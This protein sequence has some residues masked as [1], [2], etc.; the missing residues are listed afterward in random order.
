MAAN[1]QAGEAPQPLKVETKAVTLEAVQWV[2]SPDTE[3]QQKARALLTDEKFL[4]SLNSE[5]EYLVFP[6]ES[7]QLW[8]V[9]DALARNAAPPAIETLNIIAGNPLYRDPGPRRTVLL[10]SSQNA[11]TPPANVERFWKEQVRPNA[12]ELNLAVE[13][14][15]A[16]GSP[17]AIKILE[18]E[19]LRNEH[20][21]DYLVAWFQDPILRH[22]QDLVLLEASERLLRTEKWSEDLKHSLVEALFDYR[23]KAWYLEENEPPKPP[24]RSALTEAERRKLQE[25]ADLAAQNGWLTRERHAQIQSELKGR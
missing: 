22:R 7:L 14:L 11:R 3:S 18:Q 1:E 8:F 13:T 6:A 16:N 23:P 19:F 4:Q 15:V 24:P 2:K 9:L 10:K 5:R 12:D 25:I 17:A 21:P 20:E